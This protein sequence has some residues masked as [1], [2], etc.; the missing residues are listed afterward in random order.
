MEGGMSLL[1]KTNKGK[2]LRPEEV[3]LPQWIGANARI[4]SE[5]IRRGD[6]ATAESQLTYCK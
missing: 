5:L 1:G 4:Q 3:S 2:Y 6:L